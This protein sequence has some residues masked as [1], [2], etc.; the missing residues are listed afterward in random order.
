MKKFIMFMLVSAMLCACGVSKKP[1]KSSSAVIE[2]SKSEQSISTDSNAES[3]S[4]DD[5]SNDNSNPTDQ[6]ASAPV[7]D[8]DAAISD[9]KTEL[10]NPD[11]FDYVSEIAIVVKEEEKTINLLATVKD[12][13]DDATALD[14]A[15]TLVRRFSASCSLYGE[16]LKQPE[17]ES[18]GGIFDYYNFYVGI[19]SVSNIK[20]QD[21]WYVFNYVD[22][23]SFHKFKLNK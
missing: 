19:S 9:V 4:S 10:T 7:V 8:F 14:F 2:S 18:Y 15:D 16:D 12:G 22:A 3:V 20:N 17:F 5:N 21:A 1:E 11:F 6:N 13:T 23:G